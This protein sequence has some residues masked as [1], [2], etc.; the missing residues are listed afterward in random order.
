MPANLGRSVYLHSIYYNP[1]KFSK[2]TVFVKPGEVYR[3]KRLWTYK[4]LSNRAKIFKYTVVLNLSDDS[5][6]FL[7]DQKQEVFYIDSKS[8][9]FPFHQ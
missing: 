7:E 4:E 3:K 6:T 1:S 5:V 8:E 9:Y 2:N